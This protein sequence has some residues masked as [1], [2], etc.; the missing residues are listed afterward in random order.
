M[1]RETII[2][3]VKNLESIIGDKFYTY[4]FTHTYDI[5]PSPIYFKSKLAPNTMDLLIAFIQ[6]EGSDI[7]QEYGLGQEEVV[8]LLVKYYDGESAEPKKRGVTEINL[9]DNWEIWAGVSDKVMG[10]ELFKREGLIE[11]LKKIIIE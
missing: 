7:D 9:Y 8:P 3:Q 2:N 10:I 5:K 6:F 4:K 11:D 1:T